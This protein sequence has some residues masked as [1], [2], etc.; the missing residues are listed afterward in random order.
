MPITS[1]KNFL[2]GNFLHLGYIH[3][4]CSVPTVP[5]VTFLSQMC[6]N[7]YCAPT[8]LQGFQFCAQLC[9]NCAPTVPKLARLT[10]CVN[11]DILT[12]SEN[13]MFEHRCNVQIQAES[14]NGLVGAWGCIRSWKRRNHRFEI[15]TYP[16]D[17]R[18]TSKTDL[19]MLFLSPHLRILRN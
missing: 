5:K 8:V 7:C 19:L 16:I 4:N 6:P 1:V 18:L 17:F 9:P 2:Q 10:N 14:G 12:Y 3:I 15:A 11:I 13:V